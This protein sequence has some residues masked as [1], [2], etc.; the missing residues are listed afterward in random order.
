M[1]QAD[2]LAVA[3]LAEQLCRVDGSGDIGHSYRL[4]Q[5]LRAVLAQ[6]GVL[7][8]P[9]QRIQRLA[10][11]LQL[12]RRVLLRVQPHQLA[13]LQ[14]QRTLAA[15][16]HLPRQQ[17]GTCRLEQRRSAVEQ[18]RVTRLH[19]HR[20]HRRVAGAGETDETAVPAAVAD[21]LQRQPRDLTGREH[22]HALFGLQRLLHRLQ[23]GPLGTA[24][25]DANGQQQLTQW[26]QLQ[27]HV[28]GDDPH[29]VADPPHHVQQGQRI[30]RPGRV[31]GDDQQAAAG[32]NPRQRRRIH[33]IAGVQEAQRGADEGK[34]LQP[35]AALQ[36]G[37]HLVET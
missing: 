18:G 33:R 10:H 26:F 5:R 27:Q 15:G 22:D 19:P 25:K 31:V 2:L 34:A 32:R 35:G 4:G 6:L 9:A 13:D 28:V 23:A 3:G 11:R 21:T 7:L 12:P 14:A 24:A 37:V 29:V 17:G 8:L 20:Q 16:K 30:Q 1:G 36:E